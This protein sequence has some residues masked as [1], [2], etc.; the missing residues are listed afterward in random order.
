MPP[1]CIFPLLSPKHHPFFFFNFKSISVSIQY[2]VGAGVLNLLLVKS[3]FV[4]Y[5]NPALRLFLESGRSQKLSHR[6]RLVDVNRSDFGKEYRLLDFEWFNWWLQIWFGVDTI[7]LIF[8]LRFFIN[9]L[10]NFSYFFIF[11]LLMIIIF[12]L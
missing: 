5:P 12:I 8:G 10:Y 9:F 7:T 4:P 1:V 2:L 6:G 11:S 3:D